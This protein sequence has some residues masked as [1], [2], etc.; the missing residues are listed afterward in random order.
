MPAGLPSAKSVK[1][2]FEGLL[3]REVTVSPAKPMSPIDSAAFGVFVDDGNRMTAVLDLDLR[4][5]AFLGTSVALIPKG[6]AEAAIE[7]RYISEAV[8]EN[9][10]EALNIFASILN[11]HGDVH[12]RLHSTWRGSTAAPSDASALA[13]SVGKRLDLEV[14]ID[15]YGS[16]TLSCVVR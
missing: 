8:F 13:I 9:V 15:R 2:L 14:E 10:C 3:G 7:E 5:A 6:G 12:Q 11:Q 4:M 16:G 1:D